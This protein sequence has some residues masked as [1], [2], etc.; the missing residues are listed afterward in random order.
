MLTV[1]NSG[2]CAERDISIMH[3]LLADPRT[4]RTKQKRLQARLKI[5]SNVHNLRNKCTSCKEVKVKKWKRKESKKNKDDEY[6]D[7]DLDTGEDVDGE[8]D[9]KIKDEKSS[10]C[11]CPLFEVDDD[12]L[13]SMNDGQPNKRYLADLK[14]QKEEKLT[15]KKIRDHIKKTDEEKV[16]NDLKIE[17]QR[18][19]RKVREDSRLKMNQA[20]VKPATEEEKKEQRLKRK[21]DLEDQRAA[22]RAEV[23]ISFYL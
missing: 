2:I 15:K 9:D 6:D 3:S 1:H 5:R 10:H 7:E 11:H 20:K 22:K 4:N 8:V 21:R 17:L 12:L 19:R 23:L 16:K 14:K 13:A 18:L